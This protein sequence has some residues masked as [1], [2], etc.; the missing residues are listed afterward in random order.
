[1]PTLQRRK[2]LGAGDAPTGGSDLPLPRVPRVRK[3]LQN[4]RSNSHRATAQGAYNWAAHWPFDKAT[5]LALELLNQ[6]QPK[7][8]YSQTIGEA[9]I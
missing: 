1:M 9:L 5:G 2:V 7:E 3:K 8:D 6:R 4:A